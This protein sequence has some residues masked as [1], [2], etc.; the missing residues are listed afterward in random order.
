MLDRRNDLDDDGDEIIN[1]NINTH[2]HHVLREL[3][4]TSS[5]KPNLT[6]FEESKTNDID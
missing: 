2:T 5:Q 6:K 1:V 4:A 3:P